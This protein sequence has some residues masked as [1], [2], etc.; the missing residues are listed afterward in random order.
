MVS[1]VKASMISVA[2][3]VCGV[4]LSGCNTFTDV[5]AQG[6]SNVAKEIKAA[7]DSTKS[8]SDSTKTKP[9]TTTKTPPAATDTT[10]VTQQG[11]PTGSASAPTTPYSVKSPHWSHIRVH[12]SDYRIQYQSDANVRATEYAWSAAHFDDVTLDADDKT[13]VAAYHL[14]N[15]TVSVVRYAL[16]WSVIKPGQQNENVA[17]SYTQHMSQWYAAHPQYTLENAFLHDGS[18]CPAGTAA[19]PN[20]RLTIHIW[21]QDRWVVNPGDAGLRAYQASR[22]AQYMGDAD[23]LFLDEHGSGDMSDQLGNKNVREYPSFTNYQ[24]DIVG[25]LSSIQSALGSSKKIMINTAEYTSSWDAAMQNAVTGADLELFNNPTNNSMESRWSFIDAQLAKGRVLQ[26]ESGGTL[27]ASF[28]AGNS[29]SAADRQRLWQLA[30]YYLVVPS[31]SANLQFGIHDA[32]NTAFST[33]WLKAIE[34]NIGS[35]SGA[36]AVVAS[37]T[38]ASGSS[39]KVWGRDFGSALVMVR[40]SGNGSSFGDATKASLTLPTNDRYLPLHADGTVGAPVT[41][42]ELRASEAVVLLKQSRFPSLQ[43]APN[44]VP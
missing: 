23:G 25:E 24:N 41:S 18:Q 37:G 3:L 21:T 17:T 6:V 16:N 35:P 26:M 1:R 40:P 38:D 29:A 9:D 22:L 30:S 15:P 27:P 44:R 34:M 10:G 12:V 13:S 4:T 33:Q 11:N 36:R 28:N 19:T 14:A 42:V 31:N 39:Y 8:P 5:V 20:C 43:S 32:W 2:L 7:G